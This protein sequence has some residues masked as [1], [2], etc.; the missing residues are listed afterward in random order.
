MII[1]VQYFGFGKDRQLGNRKGNRNSTVEYTRDDML[2]V[3]HLG[4][5]VSNQQAMLVANHVAQLISFLPA[6]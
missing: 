1:F 4:Q 6:Q 3:N 5:L 2:V